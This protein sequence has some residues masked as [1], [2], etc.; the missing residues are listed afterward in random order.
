MSGDNKKT[1]TIIANY[2]NQYFGGTI[3]QGMGIIEDKLR[4]SRWERQLRLFDKANSILKEHGLNAPTRHIPQ[5]FMLPLLEAA[6]LEEDNFLQ[7]K[8]AQLLA[9][10]ADDTHE[11]EIKRNFITILENMTGVEV[12]IF[13]DIASN[14]FCNN[15]KGHKASVNLSEYPEKFI[16]DDVEDDVLKPLSIEL[17]SSL[18]N[19][20]RLGLLYNESVGGYPRWV[21]L[22]GLGKEFYMNTKSTT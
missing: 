17:E 22:S 19:L 16:S 20:L 11:V 13:D 3:E 8:W 18:N 5:K 15:E 4:F 12:K 2:V 1:V 9:N 10:A 7:D 6:T 14:E 21:R